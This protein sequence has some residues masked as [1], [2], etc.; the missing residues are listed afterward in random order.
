MSPVDDVVRS[1]PEVFLAARTDAEI[2]GDRRAAQG[3]LAGLRLAVKNNVDVAGFVTTAACPA[4]ASDPAEADAPAVARLRGA[5]A[6]VVGVTNLDQFATGLVGQRS[7][8]GGVRDARRP[9]FVSG[10]SSS[11]PAVAVALGAADIAIGTDTAGSGRVPAAFQGLVGIKPTLGVVSTEGVVPACPSWD[12]VT[13]MARDVDTADAATAAMAGG[14]G[15]RAWPANV[16]LAAPEHAR[17]AVPA[18]LPAMAAG[19][20]E[21]FDAVVQRFRDGGVAVEPIE[22][23]PFLEAAR[24]LYDGALVAEGTPRSVSSSTATPRS[25]I[26]RSE[27]S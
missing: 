11:G 26:R 4:Y 13:I 27:R 8:Y 21:A 23:G 1:R 17:I 14:P 19:W 10:G 20:A 24:L 12:A 3:P 18:E 7:P 25:S 2:E 16:P 15:T 5:G 22:F 9:D 6:T